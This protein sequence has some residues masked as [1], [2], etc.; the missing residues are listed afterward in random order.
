L[1]CRGSPY[2]SDTCVQLVRDTVTGTH[3]VIYNDSC[4]AEDGNSY[5]C[6]YPE[7]NPT[8]V[9]CM[10]GTYAYYDAVSGWSCEDSAECGLT[11]DDSELPC[12]YDFD[13]NRNNWFS[14]VYTGDEDWCVSRMPNLVDPFTL[15]ERSAA[16]CLMVNDG[17][18]GY[19][20]E[21]ENVLIFGTS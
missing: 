9:C 2:D 6:S 16:C 7:G 20:T 18:V 15:N 5:Y 11:S 4:I 8:G 3:T 21:D 10:N 12:N 17:T 14:N 13:L 19:F 1:T